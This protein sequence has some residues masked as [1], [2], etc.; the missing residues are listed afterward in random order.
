MPQVIECGSSSTSGPG[1][2][3]PATCTR[4]R[5]GSLRGPGSSTR[6]TTLA[7][8]QVRDVL[9]FGQPVALVLVAVLHFLP[10]ED[11]PARVVATLLDALEPEWEVRF[12]LRSCGLR[13]GCGCHDAIVALEG[14][15]FR[16]I[17]S[18]LADSMATRNAGL[19]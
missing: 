10:D 18:D 16:G 4:W 7:D 11:K 6:T 13:P 14:T 9:D 15:P 1:C 2:R 3:P 17:A 5:S 8:P 12:E 19:S